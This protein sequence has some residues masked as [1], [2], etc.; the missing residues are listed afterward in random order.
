[1][2]TQ[3]DEKFANEWYE[4]IVVTKS[5]TL[6]DLIEG[7]SEQIL[8]VDIQERIN[9]LDKILLVIKKFDKEFLTEGEVGLLLEFFIAKIN[10]FALE[11]SC[12]IEGT[13]YVLY[14]NKNIPKNCEKEIFQGIFKDANVQSW[15]V[16]DRGYLF[17][18][19]SFLI[20]TEER[21]N[22]LK[23]LESDVVLAF[24]T[25]SNGEKDP[26]LLMKV[27][28]IFLQIV[29]YFSLGHFVEDMFDVV[30]CYYP[31]E[32][33]PPENDTINIT[34]E[35]LSTAC[36]KCLL[37]TK[38]FNS[39][40]HALIQDRLTESDED[41]PLEGKLY[42][43]IFLK[44]AIS[45]FGIVGSA[46]YIKDYFTAFR[47]IILNP[48][49]KQCQHSI[50]KEI[51]EV[52][53]FIMIELQKN[54][55]R[56]NKLIQ[57][58]T[59]EMLENAE[60]FIVQ[61]EMGL[62][63]RTLDFIYS[64]YE[65]IKNE[66][67]KTKALYWIGILL[68]GKTLQS[69]ENHKEI[70]EES[71]PF[72]IKFLSL[73]TVFGE[74]IDTIYRQLENLESQFSD[75]IFEHECAVE[76]FLLKNDFEKYYKR[77]LQLGISNIVEKKFILNHSFFKL[78]HEIS[79]K[80]PL[81]LVDELSKQD[82]SFLKNPHVLS[83]FI[84]AL[85]DENS[86]DLMEKYIFM[87][88]NVNG[89]NDEISEILINLLKNGGNVVAKFINMLIKNCDVLGR[90]QNIHHSR[91]VAE[92]GLYLKEEKHNEIV[93]LCIKVLEEKNMDILGGQILNTEKNFQF[94]LYIV[95]PLLVQSKIMTIENVKMIVSISKRKFEERIIYGSYI[96]HST[97][98]NS[99][100]IFSN[101][102]MEDL[103]TRIHVIKILSIKNH[104]NYVKLIHN[105]FD[106]INNEKIK[107]HDHEILINLFNFDGLYND[108]LLCNYSHSLL[109]RQR[110]FC[111]FV[112][113][114][115]EHYLFSVTFSLYFALLQPML[116]FATTITIPMN[117]EL[118]YLLPVIVDALM[119][120]KD[121]KTETDH[122]AVISLL[123]GLNQLLPMAPLE[124]VQQ[125][126]IDNIII[127][128]LEFIQDTSQPLITLQSLIVLET[129]T[130]IAPVER[131]SIFYT[132]VIN[133]LSIA[134]K[135]PKRAIRLASAKIRNQWEILL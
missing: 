12:A 22:N 109:W 56:G 117:V 104:P 18:I 46:P 115:M 128:L 36:E 66:E 29:K 130:K 80:Y 72:L 47:S 99:V 25:A 43:C 118:L 42:D 51:R 83:I 30:A 1:M 40:C 35:M 5:C 64:V 16:S 110:Y 90:H 103:E 108:P 60:P 57:T 61:A 24:V 11:K 120:V 100:N 10:D 122:H 96:S 20:A 87:N 123:N 54:G 55:E 68:E 8:S 86:W 53:H 116:S 76:S 105:L 94:L 98:I 4:K 124:E 112:E 114:F 129:L 106:D 65:I 77:F 111:K 17:D 15:R 39:Y 73:S 101:N 127:K 121:I 37:S 97:D 85:V 52:I 26:R 6:S 89:F 33:T 71:L 58:I 113:I 91:V 75:I 70:I 27:F 119:Q 34:K 23:I 9:G 133:A 7:L 21:I 41:N 19:F 69:K 84:S 13:R 32:Y 102:D 63:A 125:Q 50:P 93:N 38:S 28:K 82:E 81:L 88:I 48:T 31:V 132:K 59:D 74:E 67:I 62:C 92:M 3:N 79:R 14:N 135:C 44:K 49:L 134:A 126:T 107:E 95:F 2:T 45:A 78:C 131:I